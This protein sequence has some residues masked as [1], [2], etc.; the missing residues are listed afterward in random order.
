[1]SLASGVAVFFAGAAINSAA[2]SLGILGDFSPDFS[3]DFYQPSN[4][5]IITITPSGAALATSAGIIGWS[6]TVPLLGVSMTSSGGAI[7]PGLGPV[8]HGAPVTSV[9]GVPIGIVLTNALPGGATSTAAG[10]LVPPLIVTLI[11]APHTAQAG[12][13]GRSIAETIAGASAAVTIG[14]M[15]PVV[16]FIG[17]SVAASAGVV[18]ALPPFGLLGVAANALAGGISGVVRPAIS[19][20]SL[21]SAGGALIA[22]V[23]PRIGG[24]LA[25]TAAGAPSRAVLWSPLG[26]LAN[27]YAGHI[28]D[29]DFSFIDLPGA[30]AVSAAGTVAETAAGQLAGTAGIAAAGPIVNAQFL[31]LTLTGV[32]AQQSA[33]VPAL[34]SVISPVPL[35]GSGAVTHAGSIA[36]LIGTGVLFIGAQANS[37]GGIVGRQVSLARVMD[38]AESATSVG[39]IVRQADATPTLIGTAMSANAADFAISYPGSVFPGAIVVT[40]AGNIIVTLF[41][42]PPFPLHVVV[43]IGRVIQPIYP[44]RRFSRR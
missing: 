25:T 32:Q 3:S 36:A 20:I 19:G 41:S 43:G 23:V 35:S 40:Q 44:R 28:T 1:M 42:P 39:Q 38:G 6:R 27:A 7:G 29:P 14:N 2:Q 24:N 31:P 22:A 10:I 17:A 37:A 8:V 15:L 9:A 34:S 16:A 5:I 18:L 12:I 26:A 11:G 21:N 33:G 4:N 30:L 13:V